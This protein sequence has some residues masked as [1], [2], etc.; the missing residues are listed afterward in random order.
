MEF[1]N[2]KMIR[3]AGITREGRPEVAC[4]TSWWLHCFCH[5]DFWGGHR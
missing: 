4:H 3:L 2:K 5:L 1:I